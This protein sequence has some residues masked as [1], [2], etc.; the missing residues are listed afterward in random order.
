[1]AIDFRKSL[2]FGQQPRQQVEG[3]CQD[4]HVVGQFGFLSLFKSD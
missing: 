1:M 4:D 3:F 2:R